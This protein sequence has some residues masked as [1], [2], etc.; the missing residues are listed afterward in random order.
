MA[1]YSGE[2]GLQLT[3][4]SANHYW[5]FRSILE[6]NIITERKATSN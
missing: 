4:H 2:L 6:R 5:G 3:T 1:V